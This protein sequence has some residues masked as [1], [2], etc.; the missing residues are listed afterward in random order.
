M[1]LDDF[2]Y[3]ETLEHCPQ[4]NPYALPAEVLA[5]IETE[6][7]KR[8]VHLQEKYSTVTL[9]IF[10]TLRTWQ[11]LP[12]FVL[13]YRQGGQRVILEAW[14]YGLRPAPAGEVGVQLVLERVPL[15]L[16]QIEPEGSSR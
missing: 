7:E 6:L 13:G 4:K 5:W 3:L 16:F 12:V 10:R 9:E 11:N 1:S 8:R 15:Q 2:P 14:H